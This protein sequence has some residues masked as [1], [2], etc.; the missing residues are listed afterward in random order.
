MS[1]SRVSGPQKTVDVGR[2]LFLVRYASAE[3]EDLPPTVKV[4]PRDSDAQIILAPD[5]KDAI[6]A[7]PG[8]ALVVKASSPTQLTIE[9]QSR[10]PSGSIAATVKIE[11]LS[12]GFAPGPARG[13]ALAAEDSVGTIQILGHVAGI[14]DVVA[15]SNAW[16]AGPT[17]PSRIEGIA[18]EWLQ[19]PSDIDLRY[20]VKFSKPAGAKTQMVAAGAFAGTRGR[21]LPLVGVVIELFGKRAQDYQLVAEALFLGSPVRRA[22][23]SR[24]VL[25]G[26]TEREPLVG[27]RLD[28][29]KAALAEPTVPARPSPALPAAAQTVSSPSARAPGR[30]RVF[31][32]AAKVDPRA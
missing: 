18:I 32:S 9:I 26:P 10:D 30:V 4:L 2:G 16:V 25:A 27:L 6:L 20:A 22:S 23:G 7:E 21:A 28:L 1:A 3:L 13:V 11:Q 5:A 29:V 8:T 24:I 17:A 12:Q 31:R 15:A 19:R 14:G